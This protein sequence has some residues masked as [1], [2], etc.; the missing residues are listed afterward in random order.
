MKNC[1]RHAEP[2]EEAKFI[3][4]YC[5]Q[6]PDPSQMHP[7]ALPLVWQPTVQEMNKFGDSLEKSMRLKPGLMTEVWNSAGRMLH[8]VLLPVFQLCVEHRILTEGELLREMASMRWVAA[9]CGL[10]CYGIGVEEA[11]RSLI[12]L[13]AAGY[14]NRI[15]RAY[16][17]RAVYAL[18]VLAHNGHLTEDDALAS[19]Q[20]T[21]DKL[22]TW[23]TGMWGRGYVEGATVVRTDSGFLEAI[24]QLEQLGDV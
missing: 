24:Q 3:C 11:Q 18:L 10:A 5:A 19:G 21:L 22:R 23:G 7:Q 13:Q 12:E 15:C 2:T 6:N 8:A 16:G 14:V 17:T 9:M 20:R 1:D 4:R